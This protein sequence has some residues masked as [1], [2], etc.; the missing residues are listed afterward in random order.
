MKSSPSPHYLRPTNHRLEEEPDNIFDNEEEDVSPLSPTAIILISLVAICI[1]LIALLCSRRK[2]P[3]KRTTDNSK[4]KA[5]DTESDG[6]LSLQH[7][8]EVDIDDGHDVII[9]NAD[10]AVFPDPY[11]LGRAHSGLDVHVCRSANCM[12]CKDQQTNPH[13]IAA[14]QASNAKAA[15]EQAQENGEEKRSTEPSLI[16]TYW[17]IEE[18]K[19]SETDRYEDI[20][21]LGDGNA[22]ITVTTSDDDNTSTERWRS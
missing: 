18:S 11:H 4:G 21:P 17:D 1:C 15:V 3:T 19:V 13:F 14:D 20:L 10:E 6:T 16:P 5:P 8:A 22:K 2:F 7:L 12:A 9:H